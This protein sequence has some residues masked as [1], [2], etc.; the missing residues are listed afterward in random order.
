M[1][2]RE[3]KHILSGPL[4]ALAGWRTGEVAGPPTIHGGKVE[5]AEDDRL[6]LLCPR[7][8]KIEAVVQITAESFFLWLSWYDRSHSTLPGMMTF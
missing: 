6:T 1:Q 8:H 4:I 3:A 5:A 2:Q 7:G